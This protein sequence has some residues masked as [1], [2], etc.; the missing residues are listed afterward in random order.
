MKKLTL[1]LILLCTCAITAYAPP[2]VFYPDIGVVQRSELI[3]VGHLKDNSIRFVRFDGWSENYATLVI[4][5]V[6]KGQSTNQEIPIVIHYGLDVVFGR[7][8]RDDEI[9]MF[10]PETR[11][12]YPTNLVRIFVSQG[13]QIEIGERPVVDDASKD[14]LWFLRRGK[15]VYGEIPDEKS[16]FGVMDGQDLEPVNLKGYFQCYLAKDPEAA[17]KAYAPTHPQVAQRAQHWLAELDS[18]REYQLILKNDDPKLRLEALLP[19]F[20]NRQGWGP[21]RADI[22]ACGKVAGEKLLSIFQD[23]NYKAQRMD[24]ILTWRDMDYK[25]AAP[26]LISLLEEANRFWAEQNAVGGWQAPNDGS[27]LAQKRRTV[28]GEVYYSVAALRTLRDPRSTEAIEITKKCWG[29]V[30]ID[31]RIVAEC[32]AALKAISEEK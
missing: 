7:D 24:I 23:P 20:L 9:E 25:E 11:K 16:D 6:V 31:P 29:F 13:S 30:E 2:R 26:V 27:E 8:H 19:H 32:D 17:V 10:Y 28:T 5:E 3:V 14:N 4:S 21:A 1:P 22:V 15:G 12:D 18:Q